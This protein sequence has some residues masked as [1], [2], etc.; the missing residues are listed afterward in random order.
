MGLTSKGDTVSEKSILIV[1]GV[2]ASLSISTVVHAATPST[3]VTCEEFIQLDE[4]SRP[5][6]V[7]WL[8]GF[9]RH[10][11]AIESV[12]FDQNDRM[13]PVLVEECTKT[14]KHLLVK[15]IK[16]AHKKTASN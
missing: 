12:D 7:Y 8:D 13:V 11:N 2:L 4:V 9:D 1:A 6:L 10:G 15:K 3:K 16:D 5:K 14:P